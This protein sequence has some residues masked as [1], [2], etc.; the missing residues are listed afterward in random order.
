MQLKFEKLAYQQEAVSAVVDLFQGEPNHADVF[1][2]DAVGA[3]PVVV[4][5]LML[6]HTEIAANLTK[7]Q[8]RFRRPETELGQHGLNFSV[9]ME[10]GTGKT[11]VYLRTLFELNKR[12]GWC[13]FVIV[14]PS[15]AIRE[16]VLQTIRA[17]AEH[18]A[19]EF[20]KPVV[21]AN[22]YDS[23]RLNVLR[24]FACNQHIEILVMNIDAFKKEDN[25][26]NRVN[27]SGEAPIKFIRDTCPIVLIDEPQNMETELAKQAVDALNPLF[28]LRYS[29]THKQPY[30]KVY[31][32]NPIEAY[33]Q[34]LVKQI[35]VMPVLAKNDVNGAYVV[36]KEFVTGKKKLTAKVEIHYQ[37]KKETKKKTVP[38]S[39][40]DDLF[41]K[42]N[43]NESYRHGFIVN[44][45]DAENGMLSLSNGTVITLGGNDDLLRDEVMKNQ[46]AETIKEHLKKEGRLKARGIK[47]L[48][49]FFID[50]VANYRNGGKFAKW[51]EEIYQHE[52]GESAEGVHD[53]Y[54]SQDKD[55]K[56]NTKA[57]ED[58]YNLIMKDKEKLLSFHSPLRFI[59][60]HSALKEGWDNPNVFQICTLNETR[61][62]IKK[63]Q[64]IGRGLR[65]A[66]NQQ[67]ERVRD[68]GVNILTVIPNESYESFAANL[69]KEY[70]DEC[71]IKFS[72]GGLKK[73]EDKR[74]Q[75]YRKGFT[76]D[77][78]FA[79][80]WQKLQQRTRYRVRFDR[81]ALIQTAS[82]LLAAMPVVQKPQISVQKAM[83]HQSQTDGIWGEQTNSHNVQADMDWAVPDVLY[84]LEKKTRLTRATLFE[85]LQ[86]SGRIG[87]IGNNPQ[88]FIDLAA[89]KIL[90]ALN[91]LMIEGIEY[92]KLEESGYAQSLVD[93]QKLEQEGIE[94]FLNPFTF[95]VGKEGGKQQ[96]TIVS[97]YIPL[98]SATEK[99]FAAACESHENVRLY[100]K[101]PH[102]FK[103]P[104]PI[105]AYNP[106][107]ALVLEN[108]EKV[109]F[110]AETKNTGKGIQ[111]GVD[112]DKL[113]MLEQQKIACAAKHFTVFD[114][115]HYRVVQKLE[116][117][118]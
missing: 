79:E 17:T 108:Q 26:I 61:S 105:G 110:V 70:E 10:T 59:F 46:I 94:F 114:G 62:P 47:V 33:N 24:N 31:S 2:L 1:E 76:L 107:W 51:F 83:I 55:T 80:I 58:T 90:L 97:D 15:V 63:R 66:V 101:L 60:S 45:L 32:L 36:L 5:R 69:Q 106:D 68:E 12:Y 87:E 75:T 71:G 82:K 13:K 100:F 115:V 74:R 104:T 49:L 103:I 6:P 73:A 16:G 3:N 93:W 116:E 52:T 111:E 25:V 38:V 18:F 64:E 35:E 28:T 84:E 11:Y 14:V 44:G 20:D 72:N 109:Y 118:A 29:A 117:L 19:N 86:Q 95:E 7:V 30:H 96:K 4:N 40:D 77:P 48:S 92:F 39:A 98:D 42:S 23:T 57:D 34:K 22:V 85:I 99:E 53:G 43:G 65:L 102:W 67:G 37:D 9:E 88:Q 81:T 27:E 56:G 50:K 89:E 21:N 54:F 41:D 91:G 113:G 112:I 78:V 8:K